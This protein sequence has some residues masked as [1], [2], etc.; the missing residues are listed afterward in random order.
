MLLNHFRERLRLGVG[1]IGAFAVLHLR[2]V[3][4]HPTRADGSPQSEQARNATDM[5]SPVPAGPIG[6]WRCGICLR[7]RLHGLQTTRT[8]SCSFMTMLVREQNR[9]HRAASC[10]DASRS[11]AERS[12]RAN[13]QP[14]ASRPTDIRGN[15]SHPSGAQYRRSHAQQA[16]G[17]CPGMIVANL[18]TQSFV[19]QLLIR[20]CGIRVDR[21]NVSQC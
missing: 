16:D 6:H 18:R 17:H 8:R 14:R 7:G 3:E 13:V 2:L 20:P 19:N 12:R 21:G 10:S 4:L 1:A 5:G 9:S 15:S 11:M